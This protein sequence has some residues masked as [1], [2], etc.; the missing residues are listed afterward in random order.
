M[1]INQEQQHQPPGGEY[2]PP[3]RRS[4]HVIKDPVHGTME[5]TGTENR[6]IKPFID[7]PVFQRLRHIKQMGLGDYIFPGG[8]HTRFSH[9]I[10]CAWVA[11]EIAEKTSLAEPERQLVL[12]AC[13]LHDIGHGPFSHV[14]EDL[15]HDRA[16][17]HEAWTPLFL[18]RFR[19]R[20]F[21]E[22]YNQQNPQHPLT[23]DKFDQI[24]NMIMHR[25]K[26]NSLLADIVSSQLDADRLDYLLRD[27]HFCGVTYGQFDLNWLLNAMVPLQTKSGWRLGI[28]HKGTGVVEQYLMARRLM[29]KNIYHHRKKLAI[30]FFLVELLASLAR[31]AD[32]LPDP[33]LAATRTGKFLLAVHHFNEA[34]LKQ[35]DKLSS[36]RETFLVTQYEHYASMCDDDI[37]LLLRQLA[38][39]TGDHTAIRLAKRILHRQMP[40][41]VDCLPQDT[42]SLQ[43]LVKDFHAENP[44]VASWQLALIQSPHH[45]YLAKADPI[46]VERATGQIEALDQISPL[47]RALSDHTEKTVFLCIDPDIV[48]QPGVK[49]LLQTVSLL[50]GTS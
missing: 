12:L 7:S 49:G 11:S 32:Q 31:E 36:L 34:L 28:T 43:S 2:A 6:W 33:S 45:S 22:R 15:F 18:A 48:E 30:E 5:F 47:I 24:E 38:S 46:L 26:K 1:L 13:L 8:V 9:S 23:T 35:P 50:T 3:D 37:F 14:F 10:G 40:V 21:F 20:D 42:A 4:R 17:R 44:G 41:I 25:G 16:I 39:L 27:N 29:T 19:T